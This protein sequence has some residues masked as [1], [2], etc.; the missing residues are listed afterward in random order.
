MEE[1]EKNGKNQGIKTIDV[2]TDDSL[3]VK[4]ETANLTNSQGYRSIMNPVDA[5][6]TGHIQT[7]HDCQE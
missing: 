4:Q 3:V 5:S 7:G 1:L 6:S 2:V